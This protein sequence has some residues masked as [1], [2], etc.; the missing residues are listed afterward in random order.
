MKIDH[1]IENRS[2]NRVTKLACSAVNSNVTVFFLYLYGVCVVGF[3][4][5]AFLMF[6]SGVFWGSLFVLW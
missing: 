6:G 1:I 2:H 4:L 5:G 3:G